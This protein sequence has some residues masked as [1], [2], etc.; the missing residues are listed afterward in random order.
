M[1]T[2]TLVP[3]VALVVGAG[4]T[5]PDDPMAHWNLG[6]GP[7][8]NVSGLA[9][10]FAQSNPPSIADAVIS[11]AEAPEI[12]TTVAADGTFMLSV[13][14]GAPISLLLQEPGFHDTQTA[15]LE[16]DVGGLDQ[17][18][19]QVPTD[20]IFDLLSTFARINPDPQRCQIATTISRKD[21]APYGGP[22]LGEPGVI[23]TINPPLPATAGPIY[24]QYV[25]DTTIY[26]DPT[27]TASTIDGGV[28]F[29]NVPPGEYTLT[30]TKAAM[31]F[32]SV[33][34]RCRA[35]VLVNAA[36]PRGLQQL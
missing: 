9:S 30:A 31:A 16:L 27:L 19:F 1:I 32:S 2:K 8:A 28:L 24:F 10:V 36:P 33:T 15:A 18:G 29:A 17:V 25:N 26:P 20:A 3:L 4:C 6:T 21:T 23:V 11:V 12:T 13:P 34:L 7:V 14:S 35:G 5:S 22:G